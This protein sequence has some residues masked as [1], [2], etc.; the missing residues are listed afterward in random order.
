MRTVNDILQSKAKPFNEIA[1]DTLV[2]DALKMLNSINLSYLVVMDN[3]QYKGIFSERDY[4]RNVILKG[5]HSDSTTVAEVMTIDLPV[6]EVDATVEQC[7]H[8]IDQH[9]TRYLLVF[10]EENSLAGVITIHDL[11]RQILSDNSLAQRLVD[12]DE[13]DRGIY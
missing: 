7:I 1:S 11:L 10:N 9:K 4:S 8:L 5:R 2:I 12:E 3:D 13:G 6:V